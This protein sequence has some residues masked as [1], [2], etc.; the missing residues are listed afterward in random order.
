MIKEIVFWIAIVYLAG[1]IV[2]LSMN[3]WEGTFGGDKYDR[4][5]YLV[6]KGDV[7]I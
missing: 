1:V 3:I 5:H 2:S 7:I 4:E 6:Q